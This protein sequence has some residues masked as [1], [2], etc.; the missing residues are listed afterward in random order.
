MKMV[1]TDYGIPDSYDV[2]FNDC[3]EM[4]CL[5]KINKSDEDE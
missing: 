1:D 4:I 5:I 2:K 3:D